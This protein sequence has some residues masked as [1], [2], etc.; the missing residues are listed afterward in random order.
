[1]GVGQ[2]FSLKIHIFDKSYDKNFDNHQIASN[3]SVES[4]DC[5][6]QNVT[7]YHFFLFFEFFGYN[8]KVHE[9]GEVGAVGEAAKVLEVVDVGIGRRAM[10]I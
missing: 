5:H 10:F 9:V 1:M 6:T 3:I 7:I 2:C 4:K 8:Y